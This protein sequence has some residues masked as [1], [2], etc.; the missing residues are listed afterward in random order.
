[1][2]KLALLA[3]AASAALL[4]SCGG[5][6]SPAPTATPAPGP[7]PTPTIGSGG[8]QS[9][10]SYNVEPCFT[11]AV[12]GMGMSVRQLIATP[13]ALV[14]D[15]SRPAGFPN[16]RIPDDQVVD[17]MVA[18][19]FLDLTESG[20]SLRTFANLPLNPPRSFPAPTTTFPFLAKPTG[21]PQLA[22]TTGTSFDFRTDPDSAY[23]SVD[24]MG[25]PAIATILV[26]SSMRNTYN[27]ASQS[28]DLAGQFTE[29][30]RAGLVLFMNAIGDDLTNLGLE[31][32]ARR[33]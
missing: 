2:R 4:A 28:A 12:P 26:S 14:L 15:L 17:I 33:I 6:D 29:E 31:I 16:G 23:T 30:E 25:N 22:A 10:F 9:A 8:G 11:Q 7:T 27:D 20:Q 3:A 24:R 32:C 18:M 1:M 13:D 21:N 5:G 19:L